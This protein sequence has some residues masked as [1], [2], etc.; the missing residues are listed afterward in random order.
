MSSTSLGTRQYKDGLQVDRVSRGVEVTPELVFVEGVLPPRD[1]NRRDRVANQVRRR[2][3]FR[4]QPV[5][6]KDDGHTR[7]GNVA[8]SRTACREER[9]PPRPPRLPSLS[10]SATAPSTTRAAARA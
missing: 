9:E 1:C 8:H 6:P 4:H 7:H 10:T 5:N 2:H 3:A